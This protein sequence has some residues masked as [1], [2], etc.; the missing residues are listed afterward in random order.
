MDKVLLKPR[1]D[2]VVEEHECPR[3][4]GTMM[5]L[6]VARP[7]GKGPFP[8]AIDIHGGGWVLHDRHWNARIDDTLAAQGIVMAAPEFRKPP[9]YKYP[10]S[11][12]DNHLAI[13]WL[14]ANAA[15]LDTR[16]DLVGGIGTSSGGH[17]LMLCALRPFDA[18]YGALALPGAETVDGTLR[19][20]VACWSVFDPLARYRMVRERQVKHLL[21][22]HA[23]YWKDEAEMAEGNP[24]LIVERRD[25]LRSPAASGHPGH[26]RRQPDRRHGG[27]LY[28]GLPGEPAARSRCINSR[29]CS[30]RSSTASR[31]Q[32][33]RSSRFP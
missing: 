23:A 15:S 29:V 21:D 17:Q 26:A 7:A 31:T 4:D 1:Y 10:V 32:P 33:R 13:R 14:K 9:E 30:T 24:Q 25:V 12:A 6:R 28:R 3:P 11:I 19:F 16:P 18:R 20:A 22:A 27:S 8:A 5:A 2:V